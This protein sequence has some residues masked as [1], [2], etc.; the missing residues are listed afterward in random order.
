MI[1]AL[2][3]ETARR[4]EARA[5]AELGMTLADLMRRAGLAVA[6]EVGRRVPFGDVAIVAGKG[7]NGGDGWVAAGELNRQ[8]RQV[9]VFTPVEPGELAGIAGDAAA[10]A[11]D[12]GVPFTVLGD[13]GMGPGDLSEYAAV[14]DAL[15][16]I[17]FA[18]PVRQPYVTWI[19]A[20][21]DSGATIVSVDIPSGVETDTG[22]TGEHVVRAQ[23]TVTFSSPKV[24]VLL[25]PGAEHAGEVVV[26][27]IGVP[28][29][30]LGGPGDPEVWQNEDYAALLPR[31]APNV[32]KNAR[33]RVLVV[34][35]SGAYPGAAALAAMGAQRAGAGFVTLAVPESIASILQTKLTSA[36][37]VSLAENPS[38]TLASKAT[39]EIVDMARESD[40]V[41][42]GPGLTIAHG[43]VLVSRSL[44]SELEKP[45]VVDADGL[46]A[47]IDVANALE[48]RSAP[49][50][51]TPHPGELARLLDTTPAEIQSDRLSFGAKLSG[52]RFACVL[53]GARTVTSGRGRQVVTL[54]GGPAL[55]TAGTGDVL[56]GM[57][58][59]LLAQGLEPLEAG[60][61]AAHLHGL[62]GDHAA[63]N[64]TETSVVAEDIP[65]HLPHAIREILGQE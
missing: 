16:G 34:A 20:I 35:G 31:P 41:V 43:A 13:E 9:R 48:M 65:A 55:A 30:M 25:Y 5:T 47:M 4:A 39:H 60:A 50:V 51:I 21:N 58:G 8:D 32:H 37:V 24:G 17:G 29:E 36:V 46:N 12:A 63:R 2:T 56:A 14:V 28:W 3:E 61:V 52:P 49:T 7:N 1:Y 53:K 64:L 10:E 27:D 54:S 44:V 26:A 62:A 42:L 22:C 45:M 40:A 33:G 11:V 57:I 15:F 23:V 19:E 38:R 6:Q 59:T 18:G